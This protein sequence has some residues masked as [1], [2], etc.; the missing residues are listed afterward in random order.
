VRELLAPPAAPH[1]VSSGPPYTFEPSLRHPKTLTHAVSRWAR[2]GHG[3]FVMQPPRR[4]ALDKQA[5]AQLMSALSLG[6]WCVGNR[7]C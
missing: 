4:L 5:K 1:L 2:V 3:G 7:H 6:D